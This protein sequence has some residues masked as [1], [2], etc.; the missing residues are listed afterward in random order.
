MNLF[1]DLQLS[2]TF[3]GLPEKAQFLHW[4]DV[5][6]EGR[7]EEAELLIRIV[8]AAEIT[9][10]NKTYRGIDKATNVLS[11]PFDVPA[12]VES[13]LL[14]DIIICASVVQREAGEL[15]QSED[16]HWAHMVVHGVLHLLGYDHL[17]D[18]QAEVMESLE[19]QILKQLGYPNPYR[20]NEN[21]VVK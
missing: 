3:S 10:L 9:E 19:I 7:R 12:P 13:D 14:G 6:L 17:N 1:L 11:F 4:A 8:D 5:A 15:N 20:C 2:Q 21:G 16:M 18:E